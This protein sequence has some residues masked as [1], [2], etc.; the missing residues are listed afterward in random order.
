MPEGLSTRARAGY[1]APDPPP[2]R[3]TIEFTIQDAGRSYVDVTAEDI[4]VIEDDV[5][6][7]I[8]TFQEA[9]D[10]VSIVLTMDSSG[11]M[12]KSAELVKATASDFVREVRPE[13]NLALITFADKPKFEHVLADKSRL[14]R[15]DAISKY[16]GERRHRVVR[17]AVQFADDA[18]GRE[19]PPGGRG[20]DRRPRREQPG[21]G[22]RQHAHVRPGARAAAPGAG[23]GLRDR[24]WARTSTAR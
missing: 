16:N 2:I 11:S 12:K 15:L 21:H 17:R 13:D 20:P 10:P 23:D 19:G 7:T 24:V 18:Q 3:P 4:D 22:A 5:P 1:F 6:Q 14:V 9:V 8:D